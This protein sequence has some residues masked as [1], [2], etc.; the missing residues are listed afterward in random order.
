[1]LAAVVHGDRVPE[2]VGDDRRAARPSLDHALAALVV[3]RVHLLEQVVI[4]ERAL[5]HTAWHGTVSSSRERSSATRS[6]PG[7]L[8]LTC[9]ISSCLL[10]TSDA[11]DE[12]DSVDLGGRR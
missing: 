3:L 11:A 7:S 5:L 4:D 6:A 8:A 12:E 2:H 9:T 1:M 10:Y